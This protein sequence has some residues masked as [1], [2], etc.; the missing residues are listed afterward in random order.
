MSKIRKNIL[1]INLF[2]GWMR[3]FRLDKSGSERTWSSSNRVH[4]IDEI[5]SAL[6]EAVSDTG[7]RG[8]Y[9][10]IVLD[11]DLLRHKAINI[12]PMNSKDIYIYVKRKVEQFKEFDGEAAFSYSKT[13]TK[14]KIHVSINYIPLSFV[15]ELRQACTDVGLFLMLIIPFLRIREQQF[16]ELSIDKNRVV[17]LIVGMYGKVSILIGKNDGTIFSD[18]GLKADMGKDV[19]IE[20]VSKEVKRSILYNKQQ[21]GENV[22]L[23]KLSEDFNENV[24]HILENSLD[25]QI[26]WLPPKP[27]RFFWNKGSLNISFNDNGNLLL[28]KYRN[29][30]RIRRSTRATL[31]ILIALWV[32]SITAS[33]TIEYL[34]YKEKKLLAVINRES[35]ELRNLKK[36]ELERKR[37]FDEL[38]IMV[39]TMEE[40]L[41]PPIPGMFLGYL[42]NEVPDG[43]ILTKTRVL[44]KNNYSW[45]IIIE[46][47]SENSSKAMK[48]N[49]EVL[50]DKLQNSHFKVHINNDWYGKW[51]E[52]IKDGILSDS[53]MSRFSLR[54]VIK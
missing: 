39:K 21:F 43:L 28:K 9:A 3:A 6:A 11:C 14:D 18:R 5:R 19:D 2:Q 38:K 17:A 13:P 40:K 33:T 36:N 8:K 15:L 41:L 1:S 7:S 4:S 30:V 25:V 51:Q 35:N 34:L 50:C 29:E 31:I 23:V 45:E 16:R 26:N 32:G 48:E 24:F 12:P 52:Q 54:G 20:R 53:R 27:K 42:C 44:H 46:G 47:F 22:T 10:S 49:L 37:R